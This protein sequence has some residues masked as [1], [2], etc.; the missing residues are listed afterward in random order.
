MVDPPADEHVEIDVLLLLGQELRRPGI[1][2]L[3]P[4]VDAKGRLVGRLEVQAGFPR[5]VVERAHGIAELGDDHRLRLVDEH[6]A[7]IRRHG[8]QEHHD[9]QEQSARHDLR[10]LLCF[11][12]WGSGSGIRDELR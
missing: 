5:R 8:D 11:Y 7:A 2:D 12:V 1:V 6:H 3:K 10:I 9:Y 4:A